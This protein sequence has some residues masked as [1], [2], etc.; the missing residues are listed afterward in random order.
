MLAI[1]FL[2]CKRDML[3]EWLDTLGVQHEEGSLKEENPTEP[4]AEKLQLTIK[5]FCGKD[6][7]LDRALLLKGFAAQDAINWPLLDAHIESL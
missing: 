4:D 7:D 3:V 1:Y 5:E 2:E 6:D